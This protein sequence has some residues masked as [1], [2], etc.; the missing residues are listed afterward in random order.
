MS[1]L[2]LDLFNGSSFLLNLVMGVDRMFQGVWGI[3]LLPNLTKVLGPFRRPGLSLRSKRGE[4]SCCNLAFLVVFLHILTTSTTLY[5]RVNDLDLAN[6]MEQF[7]E[8]IDLISNPHEEFSCDECHE[9][10]GTNKR[11]LEYIVADDTIGLCR[12]CHE[13]SHL[14]PVGVPAAESMDR[15]SRVTLPLGRGSFN[16]KI[17]CL[18]CHY[19][20]ANEYRADLIRGD[21]DL[22]QSR[23]EY[24]CS[25]CHSNQLISRSPHDPDSEACSFCHTTVPEKGQALS[26]ILNLNVQASCNFCHGAL[27]NG[28]FL[29]VNPFADPNITWRFDKVGIPLISGRFTC[30]S[31][32]DPHAYENRK[33]KMLRESYLILAARSDHVN[34]HWKEVLC[35][36][37]HTEEPRSEEANLRFNGDIN[38]LCDRCHNGKFARRD[39]HP[40]GVVPS[41]AVKIPPGMPL[42]DSKITCL[43]CHDSSL[44]EGG[45]GIDSIGKS[46]PKFLRDGFSVRNEFCF[47]CH[48]AEEYEQMNAHLQLD[49]WGEIRAQSCLFCHSSPPNLKVI[50]IEYVGFN[51]ESLDDYCTSCHGSDSFFENHP[52][53][54]HLVEPSDLVLEA[55]ETSVDRIGVELPLYEGMITCATCH[56]PHEEG[57]IRIE[58][59]AKGSSNP[60]RLRLGNSMMLCTGCHTNKL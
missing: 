12:G 28:H 31:C 40:V 3:R 58:A 29:A 8:Q 38:K 19:V 39:V 23:R 57:V 14:H 27:N 2:N 34:P 44:Q 16:N 7:Q 46:N 30:I 54:P 11:F 37:C 51:T 1:W 49:E 60:S 18:T 53:G 6:R 52:R 55:I 5:A 25:S 20:H 56:N 24:L 15:I 59:A 50:G 36:A 32:H 43:T 45:E 35:I 22:T 17:V 13:V 9:T 10:T 33:K 48:L 4:F 21:A 42:R 26:K 41:E 47:R